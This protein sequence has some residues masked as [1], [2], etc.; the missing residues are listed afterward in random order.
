MLSLKW[1]YTRIEINV[2]KLGRNITIVML[3]GFFLL[4]HVFDTKGLDEETHKIPCTSKQ[5]K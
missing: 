4:V 2:D 3:Y 1:I 5:T